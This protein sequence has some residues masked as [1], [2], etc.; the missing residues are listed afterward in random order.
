MALLQVFGFSIA[1]LLSG[2]VVY[3]YYILFGFII[4]NI[5]FSWFPGY[6]SNRLLQGVYDIVGNVA[7]PILMP[8]RS[9][10]PML[11]L[12]GM[13]LDLSPIIALIGLS[14]ARSLLLLIIR[15]FIRPVTG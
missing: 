13:G 9:R 1:N 7:R 2:V 6:P 8:I 11:Q 15:N 3:C 5:L 10:M 14:I 4:A 12:G